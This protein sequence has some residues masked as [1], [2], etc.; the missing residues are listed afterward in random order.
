MQATDPHELSEC[1]IALRVRY[2]EC[3]AQQVVFNG[4]YADYVDVAMTEYFRHK[5]G[6]FQTLLNK[7]LDT[8]VVNL[9][10]NFRASA[11]F[12]DVLDIHVNLTKIGNTSL[13]FAVL[14]VQQDNQTKVVDAEITY[15]LVDTHAYQ[16]HAIPT[17]LR[18]ALQQPGTGVRINQAG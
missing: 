7:G 6:G 18:T 5:V 9:N 11:R 16:K 4:R 1:C 3:D 17:W 12:D 13:S 8:Q 10:I 2:A 15:V 14:M